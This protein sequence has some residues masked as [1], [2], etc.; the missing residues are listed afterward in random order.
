VLGFL[1]W[2]TNKKLAQDA[3]LYTINE[4]RF[5]LGLAAMF[6]SIPKKIKKSEEKS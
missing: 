4:G 5:V 2:V 6:V 1:S 3:T